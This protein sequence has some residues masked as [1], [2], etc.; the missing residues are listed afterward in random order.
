MKKTI[1]YFKMEFYKEIETLKSTQAEMKLE[2]KHPTIQLE[3]SKENITC[4]MDQVENRIPGLKDKA[5]YLEQKNKKKYKNKG[6]NI[7]GMWDTTKRRNLQVIAPMRE[8]N[9]KL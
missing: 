3:N 1:Q 5:E 8:K 9:P 4:R 2:L 6:N 7:Q